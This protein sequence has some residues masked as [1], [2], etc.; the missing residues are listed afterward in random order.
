MYLHCT[1]D[2]L[3]NINWIMVILATLIATISLRLISIKNWLSWILFYFKHRYTCAW[4]SREYILVYVVYVLDFTS[5][6]LVRIPRNSKKCIRTYS[7]L[8]LVRRIN[9]KKNSWWIVTVSDHRRSIATTFPKRSFPLSKLFGLFFLIIFHYL[10]FFWI[11][12]F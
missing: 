6:I 2:S 1:E 10:V 5:L 3:K 12:F 7:S 11:F 4:R 8:M 9:H